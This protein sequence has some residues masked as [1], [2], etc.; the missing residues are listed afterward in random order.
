MK[1]KQFIN[2][3]IKNITEEKFALAKDSLRSVVVEKMK[4]RIR[5]VEKNVETKK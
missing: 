3:F 5:A 4:T 1:E 2:D